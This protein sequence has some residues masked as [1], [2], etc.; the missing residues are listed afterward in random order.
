MLR[1]CERCISSISPHEI[2]SSSTSPAQL[3]AL[4]ER[5]LRA[6]TWSECDRF[7]KFH[8]SQVSI[9]GAESSDVSPSELAPAR[10]EDASTPRGGS[11]GDYRRPSAGTPR[12]NPSRAVRARRGEY[13]PTRSASRRHVA[14]RR[15]R[16]SRRIRPIR[17]STPRAPQHAPRHRSARPSA[18]NA[19]NSPRNSPRC[20]CRRREA[21]AQRRRARRRRGR[22]RRR[23]RR[24]S[25]RNSPNP[26][27]AAVRAL[28]AGGC[29]RERG[30]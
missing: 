19:P 3:G 6:R 23:S 14:A 16:R 29:V 2:T 20:A 17:P 11:R 30:W 24:I 27:G 7:S 15:S 22:C 18:V 21:G 1:H 28:R 9:T 12:E 25:G 4:N 8:A 26:R 13:R 10:A 5:R